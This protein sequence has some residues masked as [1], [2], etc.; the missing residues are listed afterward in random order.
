MQ[1]QEK[2]SAYSFIV[3]P[4]FDNENQS[5]TLQCLSSDVKC[6]YNSMMIFNAHQADV[7][8]LSCYRGLLRDAQAFAAVSPMA[9]N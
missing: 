7:A 3:S 6:Q 9:A 1:K 2:P 8:W 5:L 4:F